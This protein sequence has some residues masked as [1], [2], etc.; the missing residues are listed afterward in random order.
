MQSAFEAKIVERVARIKAGDLRDP[1]T[2]FGPLVSFSH[3]DN[4][5]RFIESGIAEGARL[6]CG[7]KR[8]TGDGFDQGAWVAPTVFSDCRD[9]MK[10][11]REEIF[12]PVMSIL[13]YTSEEEVIRRANDTEYGLAAG[14]VTRDLNRAHRVIHQIEAGICWINTGVNLPLKC[15]SAVTSILASVVKTA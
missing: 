2:N 15:P 13:S 1:E 3:R 6:L 5:M 14:L 7:G 10:I 9:D 12:G 8:L 11:V 4:V